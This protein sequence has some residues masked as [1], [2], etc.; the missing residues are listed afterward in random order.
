MK[1]VNQNQKITTRKTSNTI[2]I[3]ITTTT[4]T[5]MLPHLSRLPLHPILPTAQYIFLSSTITTKLQALL[6]TLNNWAQN[7]TQTLN[8]WTQ[9]PNN[10]TQT[11]QKMDLIQNKTTY[12]DAHMST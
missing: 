12:P 6:M 1:K 8:N 10:W 11:T 9:T 2:T 5:T 3:T 4:T 7:Q